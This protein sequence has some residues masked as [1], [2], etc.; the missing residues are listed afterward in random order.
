MSLMMFNFHLSSL[1]HLRGFTLSSGNVRSRKGKGNR[2]ANGSRGS[3]DPSSRAVSEDPD[4]SFSSSDGSDDET[5]S[6]YKES[7]KSKVQI[8]T[9][10]S[11]LHG[12]EVSI[13]PLLPPSSSGSDSSQLNL[14]VI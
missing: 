8:V 1:I 5:G 3:S 6:S 11:D 14:K 12:R 4:V 2:R 9:L 7:T 13:S 10:L